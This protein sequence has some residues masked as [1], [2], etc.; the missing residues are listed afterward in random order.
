MNI[1]RAHGLAVAALIA[2]L[3]GATNVPTY[4]AEKDKELRNVAPDAV[5]TA[6]QKAYPDADI[7]N[8]SKESK[9]GRDYFEVESIDGKVRRDLL[10]LADGTVFEIEEQ[11]SPDALPE[12]IA[13][14]LNAEYPGGE[15]QRVEKITRGDSVEYEVLL[16]NNEENIEVVLEANGTIK[17]QTV[18]SDVD[19][20]AENSNAGEANEK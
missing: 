18:V 9:D 10:Y 14:G 16:E 19:E 6:F 4:A 15:I 20:K 8:V 11:I 17:S 5:M 13:D 2:I 1:T 7:L 3:W 12:S